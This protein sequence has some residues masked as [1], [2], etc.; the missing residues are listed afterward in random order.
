VQIERLV[1]D[2]KTRIARS[3]ADQVSDFIAQDLE[4]VR[5]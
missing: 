5:G 4:V 1:S 3:F 2:S